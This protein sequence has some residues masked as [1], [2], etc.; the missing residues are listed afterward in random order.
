MKLSEILYDLDYIPYGPVDV[1][2][3]GITYN[4]RKIGKNHI[5]VAL[6]GAHQDGRKFIPEAVAAGANVVVLDGYYDAGNVTRIVVQDARIALARLSANF[7]R[8]PDASLNMIGVTGTN[9]KTTIT[10]FLESIFEK[11]GQKTGVIGTINY[12]HG[13]RV[14]PAP[15][16]TPQSADLYRILHEMAVEKTDNAVLEVSSHAL[17]QGRVEGVEFDTAIFT[18]LTRDHL[19]FHKTM[20][21]YFSA[22][23]K[24]FTV[25]LERA[26]KFNQKFAII[27]IDDPWGKKLA[28]LI[29]PPTTPVTYGLGRNAVFRAENIKLGHDGC[30]FVIT[31]PAGRKKMLLPHI[32]RHN[33]YNALAAAAAAF[34]NGISLDSVVYG[35]ENAPPAPGRL[36]RVD[37][38]QHFL[39]LVDYAHTDDALINVLN[40]LR[41]LNPARLI[42][43]FGCGGD[44]DRSKRPIMGDAATKLSDFVFI[45]SDNPR[46]EDPQR[47][48]L[49]I[50]VGIRRQ[51]RSNYQVILNREEAIA[52]AVN[53][54]QKGDII[55]LAGK[56][57]ENYQIIGDKRAH[58]NDIEVASKYLKI[59]Y[60]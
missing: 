44:R 42:T 25:N 5:F 41:Q 15:N 55:L 17:A 43:V 39:V 1:E 46:S 13:G 54:A 24:L 2:V 53:M 36:Q 12:R 21:D 57:H 58:F 37:E 35:I 40:T 3:R 48:A 4:S 19:D 49:D 8:H 20:E 33:I 51:H 11:I 31:C 47:I 6:P 26:N 16:T 7:Y 14:I 29:K 56:G 10:Y 28:E 30:E 23:S 22:K 32:G 50:E 45:T 60:S 52:A 27:N 18:N 38:G 9:G 59:K 34:A